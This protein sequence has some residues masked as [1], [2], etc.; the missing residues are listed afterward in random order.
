MIKTMTLISTLTVISIVGG[1]IAYLLLGEIAKRLTGF[2]IKLA[3][4]I[5]FPFNFT[6]WF[7]YDARRLQQ[8]PKKDLSASL[9]W[10]LNCT[11]ELIYIYGTI[12]KRTYG[13][14]A[15]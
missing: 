12:Y 11:T 1:G 8:K 15:T 7:C 5:R 10:P 14:S 6:F 4:M 2:L 3:R 9:C 13:S